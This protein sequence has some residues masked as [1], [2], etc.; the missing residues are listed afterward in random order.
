MF[1]DLLQGCIRRLLR[2]QQGDR[3]ERHDGRA[4]EAHSEVRDHDMGGRN[5][6]QPLV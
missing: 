2:S 3:D 1:A 4:R 5:P 6:T